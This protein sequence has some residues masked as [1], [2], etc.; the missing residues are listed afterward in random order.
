MLRTLHCSPQRNLTPFF[1]CKE[2]REKD[3]S[4]RITQELWRG[5]CCSSIKPTKAVLAPWQG[6]KLGRE[7]REWDGRFGGTSMLP[8]PLPLC[9]SHHFSVLCSKIADF[10]TYKKSGGFPQGKWTKVTLSRGD[11]CNCLSTL[12]CSTYSP[13]RGGDRSDWAVILEATETPWQPPQ[14]KI[15]GRK[16]LSP[17]RFSSWAIHGREICCS[18][19]R[20]TAPKVHVAPDCECGW[21]ALLCR[22][23]RQCVRKLNVG[24]RVTRYKLGYRVPMRLTIV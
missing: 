10:L 3:E 15:N 5:P 8:D 12:G 16:P 23:A 18:V 11:L 1:P 17:K 24:S 21:G 4:Y 13:S 7:M 20:A 14:C 22:T 9:P 6:K 2:K 19:Y